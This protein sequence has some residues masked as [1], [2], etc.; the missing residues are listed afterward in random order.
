MDLKDLWEC[1][2]AS[3]L[4]YL[5]SWILGSCMW[6]Y[7]EVLSFWRVKRQRWEE[8]DAGLESWVPR[9][10]AV[11]S[12]FCGAPAWVMH[13][14]SS[15]LRFL[16]CQMRRLDPLISMVPCGSR[17][18]AIRKDSVCTSSSLLLRYNWYIIWYYFQ[19]Y[20]VMIWYLYILQ[21]DHNK[22]S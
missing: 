21:N 22:S 18:S 3:V 4:P 16:T 10:C 11:N 1:L 5:L 2:T 7:V 9:T 12:G 6:G 8:R 17:R 14:M 20:N 13:A 15:R 19:V